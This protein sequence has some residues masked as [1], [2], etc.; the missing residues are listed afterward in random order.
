MAE[1][2]NR[3]LKEMANCML[4]ARS[5]SS[6]LWACALY[7]QNRSPHK[8][9]TGK[10]PFEAWAG[11]QPEVSHFHIFGSRAWAR[12]PTEKRKALKPQ[13]KECM[14]FGYYDEVKW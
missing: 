14:F 2:K 11:M 10:T 5:L 8:S 9:I 6:K 4:H 1:I 13:S 12:I 3:S 7:I